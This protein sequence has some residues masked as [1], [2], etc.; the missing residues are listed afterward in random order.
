MGLSG[1]PAPVLGVGA[2][3]RGKRWQR[4]SFIDFLPKGKLLGGVPPGRGGSSLHRQEFAES[5]F[6]N[7]GV[8]PPLRPSQEVSSFLS[9]VS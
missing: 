3:G 2:G 9:M 1:P 4:K 6:L 5:K 8:N 7:C